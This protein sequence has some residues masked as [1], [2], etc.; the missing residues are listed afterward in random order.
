MGLEKGQQPFWDAKGQ[1]AV[2]G[3]GEIYNFPE[4]QKLLA[5]RG[6]ILNT[7]SD[8]EAIPQLIAEFGLDGIRLLRG[9]FALVIYDVFTN[10][11]HLVRDRL[12][13]MPLVYL[14]KSNIF[15]FSSELSPLIRAGVVEPLFD[16]M[17]LEN[18]HLY[19]FVPE[20]Q[21]IIQGV[22]KVPPGCVLSIEVDSCRTTI[23][24]Y[25]NA[26][27][28][29][30]KAS[31]TSEQMELNLRECVQ[32][33]TQS[34]VPVAVALSGG[35]DSSLVAALARESRSDL[36]AFTV[37]YTQNSA[38]DESNS[39]AE[40]ARTIDLPITHIELDTKNIARDFGTMCSARDE[41]ITD[42]AGSAYFALAQVVHDAGFPVLLNGQGGDELFWGYPW[43]RDV[44]QKAFLAA[45][46][47]RSPLESAHSF[48]LPTSVSSLIREIET[49][50]GTR[51]SKAFSQGGNGSNV[52]MNYFPLFEFQPGFRSF[53]RDRNHL[54]TRDVS[55]IPQSYSAADPNDVGPA[56][57][58]TLLN[59]YLRS[60][61]LAQMDR[62]TMRSSVEARTPLVDYRLVELM[63][64][65][66]AIPD[67]LF[68]S[69][70]LALRDVAAE[71]AP[72][73]DLKRP[74]QGFT[75]PPPIR[76]WNRMIWQTYRDEIR[77]PVIAQPHVL[78]P[79]TVRRILKSPTKPNGRVNQMA[80]RLLTLEL[81]YRGL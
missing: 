10:Q 81:W 3:N 65:T 67:T 28:C 7:G 2:L 12:G 74:K 51:I 43:V 9:M 42:S 56:A 29:V 78:N 45:G 80:L 32:I 20:N 71:L 18:Y 46:G 6:H 11:V 22:K 59:T 61:G 48:K 33:A 75:P 54:L 50:A 31:V 16:P 5:D 53:M 76:S 44:A 70:K 30:G 55:K 39:A 49:L 15:W 21:T 17:A 36:R 34:D 26:L 73:Y 47:I 66:Q 57:M 52:E 60:N 13:E 38:T 8:I 77:N 64:S 72:T 37:G 19:G 1:F 69:P 23:R 58:V 63:L 62:L 79:H 40:F 25:W 14:A 27:D 41:P 68:A 24:Q 4:L 35:L